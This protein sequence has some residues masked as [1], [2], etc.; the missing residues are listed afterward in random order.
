MLIKVGKNYYRDFK[1]IDETEVLVAEISG[2]EIY[3]IM[4]GQ[5]RFQCIASIMNEEPISL[6]DGKYLWESSPARVFKND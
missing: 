2:E 5:F 1:R 3:V 6:K 4:N